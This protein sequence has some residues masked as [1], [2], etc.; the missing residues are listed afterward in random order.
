MATIKSATEKDL[1]QAIKEEEIAHNQTK[2]ELA[3]I[4]SRL[5][6]I[7]TRA[8]VFK[9]TYHMHPWSN[10]RVVDAGRKLMEVV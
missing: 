8:V 4:K 5:Y 9:T 3:E 6:K 1:L 10:Q 7:L 2:A